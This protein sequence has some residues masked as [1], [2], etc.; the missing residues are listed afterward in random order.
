MTNHKTNLSVKK[1]KLYNIKLCLRLQVQYKVLLGNK[2]YQEL[3][4]ESL[5]ARRWYKRLYCMLKTMH[6][7][8]PNYLINLIPKCNFTIITRTSHIPTFHCRTDCFTSDLL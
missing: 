6:E 7:Q 3:G 2:I 8:I 5:K 4:L 1:L